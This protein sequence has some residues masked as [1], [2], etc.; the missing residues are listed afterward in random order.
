MS[1]WTGRDIIRSLKRKGFE[2]SNVG[3]KDLVLMVSGKK[4]KVRTRVSH[5]VGFEISPKNPVFQ[6]MKRQL[7]LDRSQLIALL[8]CPMKKRDLVQ[9][10]RKTNVIS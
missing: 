10:L 1:S 7:H 2:E 5:S 9:I 3:H 8:D 4:T 6:S